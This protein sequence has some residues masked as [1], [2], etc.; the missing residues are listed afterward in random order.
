MTDTKKWQGPELWADWTGEFQSVTYFLE[1]RPVSVLGFD[2]GGRLLIHNDRTRPDNPIITV[3][4]L[5]KNN[6]QPRTSLALI[7]MCPDG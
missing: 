3:A 2:F 6:L 1:G 7:D 4:R 5:P